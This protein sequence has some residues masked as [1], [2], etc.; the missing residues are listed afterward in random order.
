MMKWYIT[1]I[2][3]LYGAVG[4]SQ[5]TKEWSLQ[6]CIDYAVEHNITIKQ[7]QLDKSGSEVN[8]MQSKSS[9]L[10]NLSGSASQSL[11]NGSTIDPITSDYVSQQIHSTSLGLNSSVTLFQG[12]T[13]NNSIKQSKLF[14]EQDEF[15]VE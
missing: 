5:E 9:R 1:I 7:A 13:I 8:V 11:S 12:N 2:C 10:P 4:L 15:Y 3:V 14:L 6:D